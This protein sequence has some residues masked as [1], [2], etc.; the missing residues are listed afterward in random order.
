MSIEQTKEFVLND[1]NWFRAKYL[2]PLAAHSTRYWT[3]KTALNLLMQRTS[4][5]RIILETGCVRQAIPPDWGAGNSTL[6][7]GDFCTRYGGKL[8]SVDIEQK[9]AELCRDLMTTAGFG[10][11]HTIVVD[12]SVKCLEA[13]AADKSNAGAVG[14]LYLDSL[15]VPL[16]ELLEIYGGKTDLNAALAT[17]KAMTTEEIVEKHGSIFEVCQQHCLKE[18]MVSAPLL[19]LN[20]LM[21][22]DDLDLPSLGKPRLAREWLMQNGWEC[23]LEDYQT[24]WQKSR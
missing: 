14:L 8:V 3:F 4:E 21:L 2:E 12:D 5:T 11:C 20:A 17:L 18:V 23:I 22:I 9:N 7:F 15:D 10:G 13:M 6:I 16:G 19:G 1:H 24:L